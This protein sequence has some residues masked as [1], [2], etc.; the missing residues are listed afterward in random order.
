MA[1]LNNL[2]QNEL[3]GGLRSFPV[4]LIPA[5]AT[6]VLLYLS[7]DMVGAWPLAWFALVPLCFA[8]R[9][10]GPIGALMLAALSFSVSTFAQ[11]YWLLDLDGVNAPLIWL[12]A[13][14]F[15]TLPFAAIELPI[16]RKIPWPLRPF[17]L[18][19]LATGFYALL[20]ADAR[21]LI[22]LGGL[23]DSSIVRQ[24]YPQFGLATVAGVFTALAWSTAEMFA[25]PRLALP[26]RR[27]WPGIAF[28]LALALVAGIDWAGV[29]YSGEGIRTMDFVRVTVIPAGEDPVTAS[30]Q[31][32]PPGSPEN[33]I[34]WHAMPGADAVTR[35]H[36]QARA[37][38]LSER[39][40]AIVVML[41]HDDATDYGYV[42][43]RNR[44]PTRR[45][46]WTP[47]IRGEA[48]ELQGLDILSF[49]PSL[50]PDTHWSTQWSIEVHITP[51]QPAS[52]A[53]LAY[54]MREQRRG[55]VV[56]R[57]R[58]ICVWQGGGATI[59]GYGK[60]IEYSDD[61]TPFQS[62]LAA[63][64]TRGEPLGH[65]RLLFI[66]QILALSA[67][68]LAGMLLLLTPV[69]WAKRRYFLKRNAPQAFAIEENFDGDTTLSKEET[70]RIT[71]SFRRGDLKDLP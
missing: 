16:C 68:V 32:V 37:G 35:N 5:L 8:C 20:P 64:D 29:K 31:L 50:E 40:Q 34:V 49:Y 11:A 42:F 52:S 18:A 21:M 2:Q 24:V 60:V 59:D 53:Q 23:I 4:R 15:A 25:T 14:V 43:L 70:D 7:G 1:L 55:A 67:P 61:G 45:K 22:P 27:S 47:E 56:R 3:T 62:I 48:L 71:R 30:E 26:P 46:V 19:L 6:S 12:Q 17:V 13:A 10:A 57:A 9:G 69:A 51:Q 41:L 58:L 39:R 36:W 54:W 28:A 66:E 44:V 63:S 65:P 38:E 33:I